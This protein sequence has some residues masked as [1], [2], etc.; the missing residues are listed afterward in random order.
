[1]PG[2][3]ELSKQEVRAFHDW[4]DRN[5]IRLRCPVCDWRS[6]TKHERVS[7][8][9]VNDRTLLYQARNMTV[10]IECANCGYKLRFGGAV[11]EPF[12]WPATE[13]R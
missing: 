3:F 2:E 6:F 7:V 8:N 10:Q 9:T 1:M 5:D 13:R 12:F 4:M 11:A